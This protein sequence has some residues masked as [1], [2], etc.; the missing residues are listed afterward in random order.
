MPATASNAHAL[1]YGTVGTGK[2]SKIP[3]GNPYYGFKETVNH[4]G[5]VR[6]KIRIV[7]KCAIRIKVNELRFIITTIES[8]RHYTEPCP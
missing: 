8:F 3:R 2:K 4:L 6:T 5:I 7:E 1:E